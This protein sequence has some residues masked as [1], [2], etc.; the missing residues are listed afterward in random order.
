MWGVREPGARVP[1]VLDGRVYKVCIWFRQSP[2]FS[3]LG[4]EEGGVLVVILTV[5]TST[6]RAASE[7][8]RVD[9]NA[10]VGLCNSTG[11]VKI[12]LCHPSGVCVLS[13]RLVVFS[14]IGGGVFGV[15]SVP[16]VRCQCSCKRVKRK[17]GRFEGVDG[18]YVGVAS[19]VRVLRSGGLCGCF[20]AS[21]AFVG[22]GD[23]LVLASVSP[24]G[25][26]YHV[27]SSLCVFGGDVSGRGARR[28]TSLGMTATRRAEFKGV[29]GDRVRVGGGSVRMSGCLSGTVYRS[30]STEHF[31]TFCCRHPVFGV[32]GSRRKLLRAIALGSRVRRNFGPRLVCFA[33]PFTASRRV[34]MV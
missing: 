25:G 24:V 29:S 21:S 2:W 11:R 9:L 5:V 28:F 27:G 17:P 31:T 26:F 30:G 18:S 1:C 10:D 14:S 7:A 13:G 16:S 20:L 12:S 34:C 15:F 32:C 19:N 22:S 33:R 23:R 4:V 8:G 3:V 6:Y